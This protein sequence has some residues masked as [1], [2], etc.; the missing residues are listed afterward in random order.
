ME[1]WEGF[2]GGQQTQRDYGCVTFDHEQR[3]RDER[4]LA[5]RN[6]FRLDVIEIDRHCTVAYETART[7]SFSDL[8]EGRCRISKEEEEK[9]FTWD[10]VRWSGV[11]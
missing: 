6:E 9:S 2:Y 4:E 3:R 1:W 10:L 5:A 11:V 8:M 7:P